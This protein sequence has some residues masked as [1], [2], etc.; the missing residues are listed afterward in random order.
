MLPFK[1]I[2]RLQRKQAGNYI[3]LSWWTLV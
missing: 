2:Q 3:M 1:K